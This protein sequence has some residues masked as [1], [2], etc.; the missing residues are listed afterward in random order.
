MLFVIESLFYSSVCIILQGPSIMKYLTSDKFFDINHLWCF[1]HHTILNKTE[2]DSLLYSIMG[3]WKLCRVY[4]DGLF[5][6][7]RPSCRNGP[8]NR[9]LISFTIL[10]SIDLFLCPVRL[11]FYSSQSSF[12]S[13]IILLEKV[14]FF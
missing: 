2:T 5:F 11:W 1:K 9:L 6:L 4:I 3:L 10:L 14:Y 12:D 8:T 13:A 7:H